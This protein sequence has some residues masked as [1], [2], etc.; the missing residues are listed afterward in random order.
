METKKIKI[1]AFI[2]AI[3]ASLYV[4][5]LSDITI[6]RLKPKNIEDFYYL[7]IGKY[8]RII[9]FGYNNV[10]ADIL[11]MKTLA[12]T[13]EHIATDKQ[14]KYL[15]SL[16]DAVTNL[17]PYFLYPYK[18]A[19][20]ILPWEAHDAKDAI[21][22]LKKG[23]RYLPD[24]WV[25]W[26]F[27]GFIYLYFEGD[28]KQAAFYMGEAAKKPGRP[29]FIVSL[30]A[31]LLAK[32]N[33]PETAINI[34]MEVYK[35]TRTKSIKEEILKKIK[36]IIAERNFRMLDDAVKK[37]KKVEGRLPNS[38]NELVEKGFLEAIPKEPFGGKYYLTPDGEVRSTVYNK[39][40]KI[41]LKK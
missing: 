23:L 21:R 15:V 25:L 33:S 38:L 5:Y 4:I 35:N 19:G 39:R 17:D 24:S 32:E 3:F 6:N 14:F 34:L 26:F 9:S 10:L 11:W 20:T 1:T 37:F 8:A 12:Y 16:L 41:Y 30:A 31:K 2:I 7:P 18:F 13:G 22:L 29:M 36:T 40:I 28:Y 27:T